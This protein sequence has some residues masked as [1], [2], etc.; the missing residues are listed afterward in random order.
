MPAKTAE[1]PGPMEESAAAS[2]SSGPYRLN[3]LGRL[4]LISIQGNEVALPRGKPMALICYLALH[5]DGVDRDELA[6][7]LWGGKDLSKGRHSVRQ[8]LSRIRSDLG[9][10]VF[11]SQAPVT[12]APGVVL[13]DFA[14]LRGAVEEGDVDRADRLWRGE[15]F[16]GLS[17]N[18]EAGW[19]AWVSEVKSVSKRLFVTGLEERALNA[20]GSGEIDRAVEELQRAVVL[21]PDR[22]ETWVH[23]IQMLVDF[24]RVR[25]AR[26]SLAD[27]WSHLQAELYEERLG[28]LERRVAMGPDAGLVDVD[29]G[30]VARESDLAAASA[31]WRTAVGGRTGILLFEGP[32][33][34][35]KT[36]LLDEV[37]APVVTPGA[38]VVRILPGSD[39]PWSAATEWMR[40]F[41]TLRGSDKVRPETAETL[42]TILGVDSSGEALA[43]SPSDPP[44]GNALLADAFLDLI[45]AVSLAHS[46]L[47]LIDDA[48]T[49]DMESW[50]LLSRLVRLRPAMGLL[51]V[52]TFDSAASRTEVREEVEDWVLREWV[53]L[54]RL[55]P[56]TQEEVESLIRLRGWRHEEAIEEAGRQVFDNSRG[57][58]ELVFGFLQVLEENRIRP[59]PLSDDP[60]EIPDLKTLPLS[61]NLKTHFQSKLS[62]LGEV[63]HDVV[64]ILGNADYATLQTLEYSTGVS[65]EELRPIIAELMTREIVEDVG[66]GVGLVNRAF[67]ELVSEREEGTG[68]KPSSTIPDS[69]APPAPPVSGGVI[70]EDL[71]LPPVPPRTDSSRAEFWQ[72]VRIRSTTLSVIAVLIYIMWVVFGR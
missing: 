46:T 48:H 70:T 60:P 27:A 40:G 44:P 63:A 4:E 19:D 56:F 14:E 64:R 7:L 8:A 51:V 71:L 66:T 39:A 68:M 36:R 53:Q 22:V 17:V 72:T 16:S 52:L 37:A 32:A 69:T 11:S 21:V 55:R 38:Q 35:G 13:T 62:D 23:L 18:G 9:P 6:S 30:I 5:P 31:L 20:V 33:G 58:P 47:L 49:I 26:T 41:S 65:A 45:S 34:M 29:G 43:P 59:S 67:A 24:G 3:L 61:S 12:L 28:A 57:H 1:K 25:E 50:G 10:E 2:A 42:A 54:R 15:P